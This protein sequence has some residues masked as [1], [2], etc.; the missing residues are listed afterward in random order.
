MAEADRRRQDAGEGRCGAGARPRGAEAEGVHARG[1]AGGDEGVQA[2]DG[3]RGG[4]LRPGLQGLGRRAHAQPGQEQRRRHRRRQEAQPGE[5]PGPAGV[6][7]GST[8]PLAWNTRLK[9]AIGAARGLAFLHSSEKQVIY[10]DFKASNILLD[11]DFTAKL[12]DF[13]L[14]KNGPSAGRSHVTTRVIGTYGY[15]A[16]EYVATGHLYVKSDVYGFGVVLLELLTGLRAHDLNRPGHQQNLV[17]WARPYLS[18]RG[19]LTSLMDQRLGGQYPPKAALQ[20]A[21]LANK[22][23]AGDPRS[24]PS[25]ADVVTALEG[26]EAMQAPDAGAK[27]HRDLPPRPVARRSSPYHDSS[28]PPR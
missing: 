23:L 28:R 13:G 16:P 25:M 26:V 22:C 6:A 20:A 9:I 10:R 12:S 7:G 4:R 21:K 14:A 15:A 8:E 11:S 5:R 2:G 17:D 24:R 3:A 19:K 1:A 18:G 27:G